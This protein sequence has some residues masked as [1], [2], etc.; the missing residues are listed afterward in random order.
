MR[1]ESLDRTLTYPR[2]IHK[3]KRRLVLDWL[4]EF[5]FSSFDL[6]AYR[7][8][9]TARKSYDFFRLL[10]AQQLIQEVKS[11]AT[12]DV[13]LLLLTRT[14]VDYLQVAGRDVSTALTRGYRLHRYAQVVHDLDVQTSMLKR[15]DLYDEVIWDQHIRIP[16]HITRPDALAHTPKGSWV[17]FEYERWRKADKRIYLSFRNHTQALLKGHYHLVYFLFDQ[18]HDCH[19]YQQLFAADEWPEYRYHHQSG[20]LLRT[21][22]T[23]KPDSITNLRKCFRFLHEPHPQK[24]VFP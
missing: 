24:V 12:T 4:L 1:I 13:R 17:A 19:H 3:Q 10:L 15:L 5:R 14:G 9:T 2:A 23:F 8:G 18:Q 7:L 22:N 20:K 11:V 16:D 6:L 21:A